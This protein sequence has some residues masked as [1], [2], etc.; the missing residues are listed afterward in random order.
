ISMNTHTSLSLKCN[1]C[2]HAYGINV[3]FLNISYVHTFTHTHT[4]TLS[5]L[6]QSKRAYCVKAHN[7]IVIP[8]SLPP[9]L[10]ITDW[11]YS[12]ETIIDRILTMVCWCV[13][14]CAYMYA[15]LCVY[16]AFSQLC[17]CVCV[18]VRSAVKWLPLARSRLNGLQAL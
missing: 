11:I 16:S 8:P 3:L 15:C 5:L 6:S 12:K 9:S 14:V 1:S 10:L 13:C 17:V 2:Q 7:V 18:C 4:H